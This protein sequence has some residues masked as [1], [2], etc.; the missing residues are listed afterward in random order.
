MPGL[1]NW[2]LLSDSNYVIRNQIL[3]SNAHNQSN[4]N[5]LDYTSK[6]F[7]YLKSEKKPK[8]NWNED[9]SLLVLKA[10]TVTIMS[11]DIFSCK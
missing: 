9:W 1:K 3:A 2:L 8:F 5:I 11:F 10:H 7:E 4:I 6:N